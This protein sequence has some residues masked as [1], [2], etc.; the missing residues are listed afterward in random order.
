MSKTIKTEVKGADALENFWGQYFPETPVCAL[1]E[2][3][4]IASE[5][6][7]FF[8]YLDDL[9]RCENHPLETKEPLRRSARGCTRHG[10]HSFHGDGNRGSGLSLAMKH[11]LRL[12]R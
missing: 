5:V 10:Q 3:G 2:C 12:Y 7:S 9:N 6:D 1:P 11:R 8:P 4:G